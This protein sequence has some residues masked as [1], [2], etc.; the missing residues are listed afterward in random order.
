MAEQYFIECRCRAS[1]PVELYHAGSTVTCHRCGAKVK[2]PDSIQLKVLNGDKYPN[3]SLLEKIT[4]TA[5]AGEMPFQGDCHGCLDMRADFQIL[6][7]LKDLKE[8]GI[9][10][11]DHPVIPVIT[12]WS[13]GVKWKV[14]EITDETWQM[15]VI[16]VLLCSQCHDEIERSIGWRKLRRGLAMTFSLGSLIGIPA[17]LWSTRIEPV[18]TIGAGFIVAAVLI[19]I[20]TPNPS[21]HPVLHILRKIRWVGECISSSMAYQLSIGNSQP[22][23]PSKPSL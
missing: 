15:A 6:V 2:V 5:K 11:P 7:L 9:N 18:F 16:P 19:Y 3:L 21:S 8:R 1:L 12:P 20:L 23:V 22:Y 17:A 13:V 4:A 10:D 14:G